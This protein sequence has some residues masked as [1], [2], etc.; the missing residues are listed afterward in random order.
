MSLSR[1]LELFGQAFDEGPHGPVRQLVII[2]SPSRWI[3]LWPE[4]GAWTHAGRTAELHLL[5]FELRMTSSLGG[6]SVTALSWHWLKGDAGKCNP[7]GGTIK[8]STE[9]IHSPISSQDSSKTINSVSASPVAT[10]VV[11]CIEDSSRDQG[12]QDR[13]LPSGGPAGFDM[14]ILCHVIFLV[15]LGGIFCQN[16][17]SAKPSGKPAKKASSTQTAEVAQHAP[18]ED[19]HPVP[20]AAASSSKDTIPAARGGIQQGASATK[21]AEDMKLHFLRNTPAM[22]NDGT[23]A[24]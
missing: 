5:C 2:T 15:M 10:A 16:N 24:G 4:T 1:L 9:H 13:L 20:G 11:C 18:D 8:P 17:R 7:Y 21:P 6:S 22:C 3:S 23:A 12:D 19:L 14:R